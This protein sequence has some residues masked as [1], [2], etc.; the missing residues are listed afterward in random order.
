MANWH[1]RVFGFMACRLSNT[2]TERD[3]WLERYWREVDAK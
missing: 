3:Y 2:A 1:V